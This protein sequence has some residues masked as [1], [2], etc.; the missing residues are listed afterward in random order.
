[1]TGEFVDRVGIYVSM[2]AEGFSALNVGLV[3]P[4]LTELMHEI[5]RQTMADHFL[6]NIYIPFFTS[7]T[8]Q[9]HHQVKNALWKYI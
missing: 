9:H 4:H 6:Q 3:I 1:M 8:K 2:A 7:P 5:L